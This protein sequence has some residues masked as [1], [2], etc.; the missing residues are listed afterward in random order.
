MSKLFFKGN[1]DKRENYATHG[2]ET[3]AVLKPGTRKYP[4]ELTVT[5]E[6]RKVEI[7]SILAEHELFGTVAVNSDEEAEENIIDL[8]GILNKPKTTTVA[9]TQNRNDVC[10]CGSGKKYKKCCGLG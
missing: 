5:S 6:Q 3:K 8:T 7:E 4:L 2:Y 1:Q 9:Q 10:A